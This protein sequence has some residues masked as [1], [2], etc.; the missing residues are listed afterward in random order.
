MKTP[1]MAR[2]LGASAALALLIPAAPALAQAWDG[3]YGPP[4]EAG[5]PPPGYPGYPGDQ[6]LVPPPGSGIPPDYR[7]QSQ[8]SPPPEYEPPGAAIPPRYGPSRQYSAN[9]TRKSDGPNETYG[10]RE[11][12]GVGEKYGPEEAYSPAGRSLYRA[13]EAPPPG[14]SYAGTGEGYGSGSAGTG[15]VYPRPEWGAPRASVGRVAPAPRGQV[16]SVIDLNLRAGPSDEARVRT[17]LPAGTPVRV[18][19]FGQG[20]WVQVDSPFGPGW[21]YGRYLARA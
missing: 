20:G 17:V 10:A 14:R 1:L 18:T 2:M 8:D 7:A 9:E 21:V 11:A 13:P 19:G 15:W 4:P 16:V 5:S 3:S 6:E 12:Y